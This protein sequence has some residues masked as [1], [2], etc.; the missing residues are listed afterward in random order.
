MVQLRSSLPENK[1]GN[2]L[3]FTFT[4]KLTGDTMSGELDMGEYLKAKWSAKK[5][6]FGQGAQG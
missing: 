4:G 1:I 5:H 3:T 2:A 6:R